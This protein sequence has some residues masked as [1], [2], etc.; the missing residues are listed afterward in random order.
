MY[1][2]PEQSTRD[3]RPAGYRREGIPCIGGRIMGFAV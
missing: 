2:Y 3:V 1:E